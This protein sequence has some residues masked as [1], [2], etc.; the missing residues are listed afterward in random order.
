LLHPFS[1]SGKLIY[2]GTQGLHETNKMIASAQAFQPSCILSQHLY[3]IA[4]S[5]SH[6][7]QLKETAR[8]YPQWATWMDMGDLRKNGLLKDDDDDLSRKS[9]VLGGLLLTNGC[10][11]IHVKNYLKGLWSSCQDIAS[12]QGTSI[13][14]SL[15]LDSTPAP[16]HLQEF[17]TVV[18]SAGSGLFT[19]RLLQESAVQFPI[20]LVRGQSVEFSLE[21]QDCG[22]IQPVL[23]G[24]YVAPWNTD[25]CNRVIVGA[26]HEYSS[27]AL[28]STSVMEELRDATIHMCPQ[29]WQ[30]GKVVSITQGYRVQSQRGKDGRLP[31]VGRIELP[32]IGKDCWIFTGLSSRGLLY[33]GIFGS[34]LST[35]LMK[36]SDEDLPKWWVSI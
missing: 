3:R 10:K 17:D 5:S 22:P 27:Q 9:T 19:D 36:G 4:M 15:C 31:I 8:L 25:L 24:K 26:T 12:K 35:A 30:H 32:S 7:I 23:C 6:V 11:V 29:V 14:W 28:D 21:H 2:Q 1:P 33:H 34:Y 18:F 20:Q 16:S 13:A